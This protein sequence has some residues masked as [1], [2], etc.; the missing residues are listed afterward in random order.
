M[1]IFLNFA[2]WLGEEISW[3]IQHIYLVDGDLSYVHI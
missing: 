3:L 2:K 1:I